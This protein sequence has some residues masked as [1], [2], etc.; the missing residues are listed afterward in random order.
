M[1]SERLRNSLLS[2]ISHDL[3]TPLTSIVGFASVLEE[4]EQSTDASRASSR[5]LVHAI[6]EEA[7]R[8]SGLVTNLLDMARLQA[9]A[10]RL[11]RQWS[12]L[13]EVVGSA[14]AVCRRMLEGRAVHVRIPRDLP[15]LQLDAVLM[16][17]LFANLFENAAKYTPPGTALQIGAV[18]EHDAGQKTVRICIEDNGPGVPAGMQSRLFDKFTRGE[19]ESAK[20]GIGL[21]LAICRAIVEAHGGKIGVDNREDADGRV[22]GARFWFTLPANESPPLEA[23]PD[24]DTEARSITVPDRP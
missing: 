7:F 15:L 2:A 16:E 14:L 5:E 1:E 18:V 4:Q 19:K 20:P 12:M 17:R 21:G 10:I 22:I 6:H 8:M 3:R 24:E 11:N 23:L 9:G 13:E